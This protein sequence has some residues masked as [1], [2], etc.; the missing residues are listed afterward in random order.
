MMAVEEN[1]ANSLTRRRP[2]KAAALPAILIGETKVYLYPDWG[3]YDFRGYGYGAVKGKQAVIILRCLV[4]A[5]ARG[6]KVDRDQLQRE[7]FGAPDKRPWP[8]DAGAQV[9]KRIHHINQSFR[10]HGLGEWD[11]NGK[12]VRGW[13]IVAEC[14]PDTHGAR[15]DYRLKQIT[16]EAP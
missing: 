10:H 8:V 14:P 3:G 2:Q 15:A 5:A 7:L 11:Q 6:M 12:L 13:G 9:R 16:G 4:D 1:P